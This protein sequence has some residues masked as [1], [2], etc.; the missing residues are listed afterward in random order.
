M[1]LAG[2]S[3]PFSF[4]MSGVPMP[5]VVITGLGVIA[6]NANSVSEFD[7]ALRDGKSGISFQPRMK[8]LGMSCQ[9][10]GVPKNDPALLEAT[11]LERTLHVANSAMVY[12]GL[13]AIECWRDAGFVYQ[14]DV[15]GPV[16]WETGAIIGSGMAGID[17]IAEHLVPMTASGQVRRLGSAMPEQ[18]MASAPSAFVGGLLG[19]GGV[20]TTV[21]SAC[22]TGT[23]AILHAYEMIRAGH[24]QR[25]LSGSTEG[26]S[27]YSWAGF[28]AMRVC[29]R[30]H[31]DSPEK[32][33]RPMSASA[34][35]FVP[36]AGAGVLMLESLDSALARGTRIY[37][38]VLGGKINSGGQ[39]GGGSITAC[40]PEGAQRCIRQAVAAAGVSP[41]A[42]DYINAHLTGTI[43]DPREINNL[44]C[45]LELKPESFPYIN[46]TKSMIGHALGASGAI[47]CIAS[48]L[49]LHGAY[50]HPSINCE[51]IHPQLE[52]IRAHIPSTC[53]PAAISTAMKVSFGFGDV[54]ACI[55][56]SKWKN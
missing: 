18:Y 54:N 13:S 3:A 1:V 26:A 42:V 33:S 7:Q 17:T 31:N 48:I 28:D 23:E 12:A 24:I 49:Q 38:E 32:S 4:A 2:D 44:I 9:V 22:A 46:S 15:K 6:P 35:G 21:S 43:A 34:A 25:V 16:D 53:T 55:L 19:L 20:V 27:V 36:A 8:E 29:C 40:N 47:E 14:S 39:R 52:P 5:R 56:F 51:D 10:A 45:A 41:D 11:F 50:V 30:V 37:A